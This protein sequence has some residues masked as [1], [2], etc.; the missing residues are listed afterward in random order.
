MLINLQM[1]IDWLKFPKQPFLSIYIFLKKVNL[2]FSCINTLLIK[3]FHQTF[4]LSK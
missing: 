1:A 2:S 4:L 3:L